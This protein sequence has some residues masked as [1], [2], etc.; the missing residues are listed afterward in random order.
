[1]LPAG[2][3]KA[4]SGVGPGPDPSGAKN[5]AKN[6]WAQAHSPSPGFPDRGRRHLIGPTSTAIF[7]SQLL[8]HCVHHD[9]YQSS[10][11]LMG[12]LNQ[13]AL[14]ILPGLH[15]TPQLSIFT[16][17]E[18][19][20]KILGGEQIRRIPDIFPPTK[21]QQAF[22]HRQ[23]PQDLTWVRHP[24]A[25]SSLSWGLGTFTPYGFGNCNNPGCGNYI[26]WC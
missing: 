9:L 26:S 23:Q 20:Q 16:T 22:H 11:I 13:P 25:W 12:T 21:F 10:K 1:M 18:K 15:P 19:R 17:T 8:Q 24:G 14:G 5:K 3:G 6:E 2:D 4:R 7:P